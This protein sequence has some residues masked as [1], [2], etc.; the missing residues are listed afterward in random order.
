MQNLIEL[1][2]SKVLFQSHSVERGGAK[3][4]ENDKGGGTINGYSTNQSSMTLLREQVVNGY[5]KT[6][7]CLIRTTCCYS[8]RIA[9]LQENFSDSLLLAMM[10]LLHQQSDQLLYKTVIS[11]WSHFTEVSDL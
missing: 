3:S 2:M 4:H 8:Y 6:V 9:S 5:Y 10:S 7:V 1:P 11:T